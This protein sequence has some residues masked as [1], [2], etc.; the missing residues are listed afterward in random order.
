MIINTHGKWRKFE[1]ASGQTFEIGKTY[2][3]AVDGNCEFA[4]SAEEPT[5]GINT[6]TIN[7]TAV[8]GVYLWIKTGEK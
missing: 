3:I 8:E 1:K 4:V 6:N 7:F 2:N 5:A